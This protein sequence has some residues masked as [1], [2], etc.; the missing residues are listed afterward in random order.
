MIS[1]DMAF[2]GRLF[3]E[4][5]GKTYYRWYNLNFDAPC[6]VTFKLISLNSPYN[7]AIALFFSDFSGELYV[8]DRKESEFDGFKQYLFK[9]NKFV[10]QSLELRIFPKAGHMFFSNASED[11]EGPGYECSAR[12]CAFWY[13]KID[14]CTVRFHCNDHE[15]D[16]DFD[17]MIF[18]FTVM[19]TEQ[20]A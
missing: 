11:P 20:G 2:G 4:Y 13:E 6:V 19:P 14:E 10:D 7:Q 15:D 5:D 18:D 16:D 9:T 3:Y 17:D 12:G 8:N 1:N